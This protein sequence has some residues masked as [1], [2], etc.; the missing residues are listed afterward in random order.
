MDTAM[1]TFENKYLE[2]VISKK[3][4]KVVGF[5]DKNSGKD[6]RNNSEEP[7]FC[8]YF[9]QDG[10][11]TYPQSADWKGGK[12]SVVFSDSVVDIKVTVR[13]TYFVFEVLS[14]IPALYTGFAFAGTKLSFTI[15]DDSSFAAIGYAMSVNTNPCFYPH[16]KDKAVRAECIREVGVKGAKYA[17]IAAPRGEHN[18]IMKTVNTEMKKSEVSVSSVGGP[19]SRDA[20]GNHGDYVITSQIDPKQIDQIAE[21][22]SRYDVDQLDFHQGAIFRQ[23]DF[24]FLVT[25]DARDFKKKVTDPLKKAGIVSGLHTYSFY[26]AFSESEML[27]DPEYQKDLEI[28]ERY[29]LAKDITPEDADL[30]TVESTNGINKE[31]GFFTRSSQ[32]ILIDEEMIRIGVGESGF[33]EC[34]R[35]VNGTAA[36]AHTKGAEIRRIGCYYGGLAPMPG[37]NLFK[38]VAHNTAKAY[39]EGGFGMIYFDALDGISRHTKYGEYY[40]AMFVHEVLRYCKT[41]PIVEYATMYPT[42]WICRGRIGAWDHATR[43]FNVFN[44]LHIK[45]NAPFLEAFNVVTLGWYNFFPVNESYP[46]NFQYKYQYKEHLDYLGTKAIA[47]GC[48]MVYNGFV[49]AAAEKYAAHADNVQYYLRYNKLRKSDYFSKEIRDKIRD[50]KKEFRLV[51]EKNGRFAF[52]ER[53]YIYQKLDNAS[54]RNTVSV[55]NPYEAQRPF[56]RI[57]GLASTTG[58]DPVTVMP[59]DYGTPVQEQER[60]VTFPQELNIYDKLAMKFKVRGTGSDQAL[61]LRLK[62]K[63]LGEGGYA[64]YC[65]RLD[66]EGEREFIFAETDNGEFMEYRFP[67]KA[68]GAYA[69]YR[70]PTNFERIVEATLFASEGCGKAYL[71]DITAV[72]RVDNPIENPSI[73]VG[74]KTVVFKCVLGSSEYLEYDGENA[75]VYD[76]YGNR[77]KAVVQGEL[78][79]L[80][81]GETVAVF[82]GKPQGCGPMRAKLTFGFGGKTV[83]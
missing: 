49:P 3:N 11:K 27:A 68:D 2:Y 52:E 10:A 80:A 79:L 44:E 5:I 71:S 83:R 82:G 36:A 7:Y 12:L 67:D 18:E 81:K 57:E 66:F 22:Y 39:N 46:G 35:G 48:T 34:Q 37:T 45:A 74:D 4:A 17:L 78:A 60:K 77:R 51:T 33:V 43:A 32:Y 72:R 29:T 53:K 64:E 70:A 41:D 73:T 23:G 63:T 65:I 15:R 55:R 1:I 28:V 59:F 30:P 50:P 16:A 47:D 40:S 31:Y 8:Y 56:L 54:E 19:Y 42:L 13:E 62:G 26:I 20:K 38:R 61:C 24:R 21:F 9:D 75:Y 69:V 14:D 76:R 25:K 58:E 6:I